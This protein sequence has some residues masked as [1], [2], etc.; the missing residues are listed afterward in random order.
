MNLMAITH[1]PADI[2]LLY[3][4]PVNNINVKTRFEISSK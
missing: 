2:Y 1:S 4:L 3:D